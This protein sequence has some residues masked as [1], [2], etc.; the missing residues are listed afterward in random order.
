L[1]V[2][3]APAHVRRWLGDV[4]QHVPHHACLCVHCLCLTMHVCVH[5]LCITVHVSTS[6]LAFGG[7]PQG[8]RGHGSTGNDAGAV[9]AVDSPLGGSGGKGQECSLA[10]AG[11]FVPGSSWASADLIKPSRECCSLPPSPPSSALCRSES[12]WM[13]GPH[14]RAPLYACTGPAP[15][16]LAVCLGAPCPLAMGEPA[17][18]AHQC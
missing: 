9:D 5:C 4:R 2:H 11:Q 6:S 3:A 17:Q 14:P 18:G 16:T 15:P 12:R 8:Q 10:A 1:C 7:K 13:N